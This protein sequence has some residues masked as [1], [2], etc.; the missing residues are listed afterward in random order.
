MWREK[1]TIIIRA[2]YT[3]MKS[4]KTYYLCSDKKIKPS[5]I[6]LPNLTGSLLSLVCP[7]SAIL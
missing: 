6:N 7:V 2:E 3:I 4:I 1:K 5:H